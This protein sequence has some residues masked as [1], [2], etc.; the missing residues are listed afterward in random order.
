MFQ[1]YWIFISFKISE[2]LLKFSK[3]D[4][5]LEK[6]KFKIVPEQIQ[7]FLEIAPAWR[8]GT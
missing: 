1:D 7:K 4:V 5:E 3:I 2:F 6:Y 8:Q